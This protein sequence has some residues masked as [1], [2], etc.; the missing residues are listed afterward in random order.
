LVTD[1][2]THDCRAVQDLHFKP[3]NLL[4][5]YRANLDYA[6]FYH[7]HQGRVWIVTRLKSNSR[8]EI[9]Q[10]RAVAGQVLAD[11]LIRLSSP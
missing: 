11:Q 9:V 1:G 4:I 3:D 7:L 6:W 8:Y 10:S 5:F 2:K